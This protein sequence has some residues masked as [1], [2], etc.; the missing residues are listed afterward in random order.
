[1]ILAMDLA[2]PLAKKLNKAGVEWMFTAG[3]AMQYL[4]V[5]D[6]Q[7]GDLDIV[8][9]SVAGIASVVGPEFV[10]HNTALCDLHKVE[11]FVFHCFNIQLDIF[12]LGEDP[13]SV[14]RWARRVPHDVDGQT[15]WTA[16]A[17][18]VLIRKQ[19]A[20]QTGHR[21]KDSEDCD[22]ILGARKSLDHDYIAQWCGAELL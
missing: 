16:T 18:D 12:K 7:P 15:V 5:S 3:V 22:R 21:Q 1:M 4:G 6:R 8:V 14:A 10:F 20:F 13:Y 2:L 17:E 19:Q 9:R 11:F